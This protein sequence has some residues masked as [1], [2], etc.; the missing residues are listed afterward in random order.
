[1]KEAHEME[2]CSFNVSKQLGED[3]LLLFIIYALFFVNLCL[4]NNICKSKSQVIN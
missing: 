1:M 3:L 2:K 4:S